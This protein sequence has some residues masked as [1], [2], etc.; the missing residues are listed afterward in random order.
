[1]RRI[2]FYLFLYFFAQYVSRLA[3]N[4]RIPF[5]QFLKDFQSD[6]SQLSKFKNFQDKSLTVFKFLKS[7]LLNKHSYRA[8][9]I[10]S[11]LATV[12]YSC[13]FENQLLQSEI[14]K[15]I[16][17]G[18]YT[19][20]LLEILKKHPDLLKVAVNENFVNM[21]NE[22]SSMQMVDVPR[23]IS[24]INDNTKIIIQII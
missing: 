21:V 12:E 19:E 2:F 10:I 23:I 17:T 16:K 18:I 24:D 8:L 13:F 22:F 14:S 5:D 7:L 20:P 11:M 3:S 4:E 9:T 1:M 15:T 6:A